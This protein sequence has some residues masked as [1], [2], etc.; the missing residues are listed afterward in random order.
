MKTILTLACFIVCGL[1]HTQ[2]KSS[3]NFQFGATIKASINFGNNKDGTKKFKNEPVLFF[4]ISTSFGVANT[5]LSKSF[6][7]S[8]NTEIQIYN[9]GLGSNNVKGYSE[10]KIILDAVFAL[11]LTSGFDYNPDTNNPLKYFSDFAIP[12]L[13]NPY[14]VS[15]SLG[16]NLIFTTEKNRETQRVGFAGVNVKG[17]QAFTY[18]DGSFLARMFLGDGE[19]R[20]YTGGGGL[21]YNTAWNDKKATKEVA[22]ELSY[23]KF[24]GYTDDTFQLGYDI[25]A[26]LVT[27][28]NEE[29]YGYNKSLWKAGA[30]YRVDNVGYGVSINQY[31]YPKWD[32]QHLIHWLTYCP[33]HFVPY[34]T[35]YSVEPFLYLKKQ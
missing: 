31:N 21:S 16:T 20:Y 27:Y 1:Y 2:E 17:V 11:T 13:N 33:Y 9:G 15:A 32:E 24:T 5:W 8:L 35:F 23:H 7:P 12:S 6:Y 30:M 4:R 10:N 34:N 14:S 18:N 22:L 29:Q 26:S 3:D 25:G 28:K 19:D